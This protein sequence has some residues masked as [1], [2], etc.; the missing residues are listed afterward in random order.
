VR[1]LATAAIAEAERLATILAT[2]V[3]L[4]PAVHTTRK[5]TKRLRS[6]LRLARQSIGTDVYRTE[7]AALR[8]TARL[9]APARDALVLI[10]TAREM[11]ASRP[12]LAILERLHL[13]EMAR[14]ESG[15]R[16]DAAGRLTSI[17]SRWSVLDWRGPDVA[18]IRA[19]LTRTYRRGLADFAA[20]QSQPSASAFH[21]WRRRVKYVRYQL[22][23]VGA[24]GKLTRPWFALGND[25]GWEHDHTVLIGVCSEYPGDD[26]FR[27]VAES[28]QA[29]REVLRSAA[30][31]A[32]D[33]LL[34]LKP[35][36]FVASVASA[37][38]F[39]EG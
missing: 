25:L 18:S 14:L 17:A 28:S 8:D 33:Q 1:D 19:G 9:I 2:A 13:E 32:G 4:D 30:L 23:A 36:A 26:G 20:V 39:E 29:R 15:V 37:V 27:S 3:D 5:G 31:E 34:V 22:E 6:I 21:S 24:P 12:V 16:A 7:N 10:E 11:N 35:R 38:G